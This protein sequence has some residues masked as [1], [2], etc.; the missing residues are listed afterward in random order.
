M[1][2]TAALIEI[3][4]HSTPWHRA[5][6]ATAPARWWIL[7]ALGL[8]L[9]TLAPITQAQV[10][11]DIDVQNTDNGVAV[12]VQFAA[13]V[14]YRRHVVSPTGDEIQIYFNL[15]A[16]DASGQTVTEDI[17]NVPAS[18]GLPAITVHYFTGRQT[19]ALR[20]V[21]LRFAEPVSVSRVGLGTDNRSLVAVVQKRGLGITPT[22]TYTAPPPAGSGDPTAMLASARS[23]ISAGKYEDAVALLNQILNLPP[24]AASPDAQELIGNAREG[25]GENDRA[26]AEYELYLKLFPDLPGAQRVKDRVAVIGIA[27]SKGGKGEAAP[28]TLFW[29]SVSQSYY[30][31]QSRIRNETTIITPGTDATQIDIQDISSNDQSSIVTNLDANARYRGKGWDDR[32][33]IRDVSVW[34]LLTGQPSQNR[35]SAAY[36]DFKNAGLRFDAR[37]GRQSSMS[38]A[39]LGRFDGAQAHYGIGSSWRVGA[40]AGTPAE[41]TLGARKS[42]YGVTVDNEKLLDGLGLGL[43]AVEQRTEGLVD[44]RA[45]GSELRYFSQKLSI[46]SLLDYDIHFNRINVASGQGSLTFDGGATLNALYDYRRSPPLQLTNVLLGST[47]P[48]LQQL[49]LTQTRAELEREALGLTPISKVLLLGGLVPVSPKWQLGAEFRLSSVSDTI[50]T[51]TLPVAPGT[52]NVYSYT[53]QAIGSGIFTPSTVL[54]FNGNRL[55]S[56]AFDAWLISA[57]TRFRPTEHWSVEPTLRYYIQDNKPTAVLANAPRLKRLSPTLRTTY[58]L[59]EKISL[60]GEISAERSQTNSSV[61]NENSNVLFYYFGYRAEF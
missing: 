50:A 59:R 32:F 23:A 53:V 11:D 54:V 17:R 1:Q 24:N 5:A 19:G 9:L 16:I 42:F 35:L 29:G 61:V 55:T 10:L 6:G 56:D 25:L 30:G 60:E 51:A 40:F 36:A 48:T 45:L 33:V 58:Q 44:R 20:R 18:L 37:A 22:A 7:R 43:Y 3:E 38:G 57:N 28:Q 52:G 27:A 41:A 26:R 13:Q 46:F 21:D 15:T 12:L 8:L 39:V 34:S 14:S 2:P 49:L 47:A 31:G 4:H